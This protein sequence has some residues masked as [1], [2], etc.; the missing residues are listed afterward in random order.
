MQELEV[1]RSRFARLVE[2]REE[3]DLT[4]AAAKSA[5]DEFEQ[6]QAELWDDINDSPLKGAISLDIPGHGQVS[7]QKRETY[8]GRVL[9]EHEL[10]AWAQEN[11]VIDEFTSPSISMARLNELVRTRIEAREALP[12][13]SDFTATR[14]ISMSFKDK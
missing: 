12:P 13:G 8:R 6:Y 3:K 11:G 4:A 5:K 10:I 14:Y 9:N 1:F 2:L 7:F